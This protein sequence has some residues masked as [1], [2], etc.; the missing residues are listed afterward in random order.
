[1]LGIVKR[2]LLYLEVVHPLVR[3]SEVILGDLDALR[4]Q[5]LVQSSTLEKKFTP[6][7]LSYDFLTPF[8]CVASPVQKI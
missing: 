6:S 2:A 5:H 1:M 4:V 8:Q 3:D 7:C